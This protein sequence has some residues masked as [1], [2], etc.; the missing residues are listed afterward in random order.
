MG[1][2]F[3]RRAQHEGTIF[4]T[5]RDHESP[6]FPSCAA[7]RSAPL[8]QAAAGRRL[9]RLERIFVEFIDLP[10]ELFVDALMETS[11]EDPSKVIPLYAS[12][13][14]LRLFAPDRTVEAAQNLM[15]RLVET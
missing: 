3:V 14:K 15:S 1:R 5:L 8:Q 2:I 11:I 9:G 12:K 6:R 13:G 7:P 4:D 10:T